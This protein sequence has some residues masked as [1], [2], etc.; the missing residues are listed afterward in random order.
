MNHEISLVVFDKPNTQNIL[1]YPLFDLA[2][3]SIDIRK[4]WSYRKVELSGEWIYLR[5]VL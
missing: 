3:G 5:E 4:K 2:K 1:H